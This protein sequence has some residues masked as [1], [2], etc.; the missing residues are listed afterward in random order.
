MAQRFGGEHTEKKL[1]VLRKYLQAFVTAL[2]RQNFHKIYIDAFA[3]DGYRLDQSACACAGPMFSETEQEAGI[4]RDG[5]ARIAL[6][7]NPQFDR[8]IFTD[9]SRS[10]CSSLEKLRDEYP[11]TRID[12]LNIDANKFIQTKMTELFRQDRMARAVCFLDPFGAQ[13]EW[14]SLKAIAQTEAIDLWYLFPLSTVYRMLPENRQVDC[15]CRQRLKLMFGT[16]DWEKTFYLQY[17]NNGLFGFEEHSERSAQRERI[18]DYLV[19]RL[20]TIFPVVHD[21][22]LH[23]PSATGSVQFLLCFT[24]ANP[25]ASKLTLQIA[26]DIIKKE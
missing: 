5:S 18:T 22:P 19:K 11:H 9:I 20:R 21:R 6:T 12:I 16:D 1:R 4:L 25:R 17:V 8:Y 10:K 26:G 2:K 13:V 14:N 7:V 3:G 23:L 24:A 15:N